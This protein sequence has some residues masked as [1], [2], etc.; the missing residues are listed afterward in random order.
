MSDSIAWP[1]GSDAQ[2]APADPRSTRALCPWLLGTLM[3]Y[4]AKYV[5][6][7]RPMEAMDR[8][9]PAESSTSDV[10]L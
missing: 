3:P 7:I 8:A 9:V 10:V 1:I 6:H 2:S 4:M 5:I